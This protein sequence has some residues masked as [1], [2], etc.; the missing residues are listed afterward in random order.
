MSR[1]TNLSS[2]LTII[3]S[4]LKN[5]IQSID[6]DSNLGSIK[7]VLNDSSILFIRYNNYNEYSYNLIF[8][9]IKYDRVRFDNFD[10]TWNVSTRPNH[11]HP[12]NSKNGFDS[13]MKG[14]PKFDIPILVDLIQ[15]NSLNDP[16]IRF[17]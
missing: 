1:I 13:P 2:A 10:D 15:K 17:N 5:L 6:L 9:N 7:C 8:S 11:F 4:E 3:Q 16:Q 14:N 12:R